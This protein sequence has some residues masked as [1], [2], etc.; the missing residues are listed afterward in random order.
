MSEMVFIS[1]S[2]GSKVVVVVCP[3]CGRISRQIL[4]DVYS[5]QPV[6][7]L[8]AEHKCP[9][10]GA[11]YSSCNAARSNSWANAYNRYSRD[12]QGY[13][14]SIKENY[15]RSL[16][17]QH[18]PAVAAQAPAQ[19]AATAP[20]Q[21]RQQTAFVQMAPVPAPAPSTPQAP[22]QVIN[23]GAIRKMS[24]ETLL[25]ALQQAI[26]QMQAEE[27]KAPE[28]APP[29]KIEDAIPLPSFTS[30]PV[31]PPAQFDALD[32]KIEYWKNQLLD[33]GK[34]NKMINYR[35]TKRATLRILE[36][37]FSELF[38][39][40]ALNEEELTFQ[41]PIDKDSDLRTFS[42]LSLL[43]TLSYPLPVH[44]GDIKTEGTILERQKTL[45]N[46]RTKS[47]LARDEQGTNILYLSFGFIEWKEN[48]VASSPWLKSP[49]L[50][51]PVSLKIESIQAPY[52][53]SRYDDE[54]EVNPTLDYLFNQEYGIDL[55]TFELKDASSIDQYMEVIEDIVDKRGWKL[56]REVSMGLLSFL[57]I[58]MYHDLN[59]NRER[60][61]NNPV[62]RAIT[63]DTSV[64]NV[65]PKEYLNFSF[66]RVAPYDWYQVV[67]SDSS[68]QEAILLSKIGV[69]FV[70]QGPPG[71][72][73]SQ[74]ITNIIAEAL[75][76]GKKVLFVS[77]K[78]AALQV[79]YKRLSEVHLDDFCLALH[80]HKANKKEILD[81]IGDNLKLPHN[82]VKDSVMAELNELFHDREYLN[83]YA[84]EL[85]EE[86]APLGESL[87]VVF[88]KLSKL[89]TAT[90]IPFVIDNPTAV[91]AD[92]FNTM[93]YCVR[94]YAKALA[95]MGGKLTDN[96]WYGSVVT[97]IS[98]EFKSQLLAETQ[99][100]DQQL[101]SLYEALSNYQNKYGFGGEA[102]WNDVQRIIS[103]LSEIEKTP[104]FPF[105]WCSSERRAQLLS[106][107]NKAK[108]LKLKYLSVLTEVQSHFADT[109]FDVDLNAWTES[110][111]ANIAAIQQI[112][113]YSTLLAGDI[114]TRVENVNVYAKA[115]VTQIT[116]IIAKYHEA[117]DILHIDITDT[118]ENMSKIGQIAEALITMTAARREWF[119]TFIYNQAVHQIDIAKS[120]TASVQAKSQALLEH[121][122]PEVF[123]INADSMLERFMTKYNSSFKDSVIAY[124]QDV[125]TI[126]GMS[127]SVIQKTSDDVIVSLLQN[128]KA[129]NTEK[130]RMAENETLICSHF[131]SNY[132]GLDTDWNN[133][134]AVYS[135]VGRQIEM[136]KSN[137][138]SIHIWMQ[139]LLEQWEPEVFEIDTEAML[140][141][142]KTE[143]TGIFRRLKSAYR[144]D[145]KAI[146]CVSKSVGGKINDDVIVSLL[147][148]IKAINTEKQ[149]M[150]EN[151][152]LIRSHFGNYYFGL[153]T[154][155]NSLRAIYSRVGRQIEM[156]KSNFDN[157]QAQMKALLE[158]W[159]PGI[160]S[161]DA[162][163]MLVRFT[164]E[165]SRVFT[166]LMFEYQKDVEFICGMSKSIRKE[167]GDEEII[168]LL[169]KLKD[170]NSE[171]QWF[172]DNEQV[173]RSCFGDYYLG[174]STDWQSLSTGLSFVASLC[175]IFPH[176]IVSSKIID[177]ICDKA[178]HSAEYSKLTGIAHTLSQENIS[179]AQIKSGNATTHIADSAGLSVEKDILPCLS[180]L[181][182]ASAK[183]IECINTVQRH[184]KD[185]IPLADM[186]MHISKAVEVKAAKADL[187][188]NGA[189]NKELFGD[190]YQEIETEWDAIIDDLDKVG[191]LFACKDFEFTTE[192][193]IE[194]LCDDRE[195]RLDLSK[196][197]DDLQNRYTSAQQPV[198]SFV[199]L[200]REDADLFNSS[201][202]DLAMRFRRCIDNYSMLDKWLD[203]TE[204]KAECDKVGLSDFTT[205]IDAQDN[206][207]PGV[208]DAFS[209]GFYRQ[210]SVAVI[211]S[212]ASVQQFRR[213]VH[214]ER[215]N[216]FVVLD[217]KQLAIAQ[218]RIRDKIISTF[219]DTNRVMTANDEMSIL[220]HELGKKRRIMPLRKLFRSIPNLLL[221]LKPCLMMSPLSV[222][223]F[224][225]AE[226]YQFDMVIFDE[227]SQIFPQDAIG[228]IFRGAQVI[229]A[230]D[231]KQLPPTNFFAASTNNSENDYDNEDDKEYEDAIYDSI[232]EETTNVLPNRTLLW[233][234]RSKHEHLIAFSNQEIYKNELVTF[235]SSIEKEEDTGVEFV[236]VEHGAYESGGKNCNVQEAKRCVELVKDHIKKH[237]TRSLG[238]IAFSEK[239]QQAIS[240][241]IQRFREQNPEFEEFFAEDKED[242]FFVKNLENVQGDERD[243][244]IFS[245]GYAKTKDQRANNRPMSMRFG[246]LGHQGGERRLN[247]A[248]TRAKR[249]VKLVSSILPSDI[250]LSRTESEGVRMLRS[251]IEFAMNGSAS[252]RSGRSD[253]G[254]NDD[255]VDTISDYIER[256]GYRIRK[257]VG[258][259]GYRIDIAVEHPEKDGRFIAGIECDGFSYIAV[260]TA[261][262]RDH[263]RKSVLKAMGWSIYRVWSTEW[264]KNPE[265]EGEKLI[266]F[267]KETVDNYH[268]DITPVITEQSV[269]AVPDTYEIVEE[270]KETP[271]TATK[272]GTPDNPYGFDYYTEA[273]WSETPNILQYQ[274]TN[275][276]IEEIKYIVGIEQ[277][278]SKDLLYQRM[279][280]AFGRQK[281]TAPVRNTINQ[282]LRATKAKEILTNS[283][284]FVI[285]AGFSNLRVRIPKQGDTPRPINYISPSEIGLA[286]LT[287]ASHTFG[288]SSE[289]LID[290]TARVLG[291]AR[292]GERIMTC[293]KEALSRLISSGQVK[294]IDGKVNIVEEV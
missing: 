5:R 86:V 235:P 213:R 188:A 285:L 294:L 241:E 40:L 267:I 8:S 199:K 12:A 185:E 46:L 137:S 98:Q 221:T 173:L 94:N 229:I 61:L 146:R 216:R 28:A 175:K 227:A 169:Q 15:Q 82:R 58:S 22:A 17:A 9:V 208:S 106:A 171:K 76:D 228:A 62:I 165:Y 289:G 190:R 209:R 202:I 182:A 222:A 127:K 142:F 138:D 59:N 84:H 277:P 260:K 239:Q 270:I 266:S 178:S 186:T 212:K 16:S 10:C 156:V 276:I 184:A 246:P 148:D 115:L 233:H 236:Y 70:M 187:L 102:T 232:L 136:V 89:D 24:Q 37:E 271:S 130:Q 245:I 253:A 80:S 256:N 79:V 281:A 53:I 135:R 255:F 218:M 41:R 103:M 50:M 4:R 2:T 268:E 112:G 19:F 32:R 65:I 264:I 200:F 248:I 163:A 250:D 67:N 21:Q 279:A 26:T 34:R 243:T 27:S 176:G 118:F 155:W 7:A 119:D 192:E 282:A 244:I 237:P 45:K 230:G 157:I 145:V 259:S 49:I 141:R 69:S 211:D 90:A 234:Y 52:T 113:N 36:P 172:A 20:V 6:C 129:I 1:S 193:F 68:Q 99:G 287:I 143:Y 133:L 214:D 13:N 194:L 91:S 3:K 128:I 95:N 131:G 278:I 39:R 247:V 14:N 60:M 196:A 125:E 72:G 290:E 93:I 158:Q 126:Y 66:D 272:N 203:Y 105:D 81:S 252:L 263:L 152:T 100:L 134:H 238:I 56:V 265:I 225:E 274:G 73:K 63:G 47:K 159:E 174:M 170:I 57:K 109:I 207:I 123:T 97:S 262:D 160:L 38:N 77:E 44:I 107:A 168:I 139:A 195:V 35:E 181:R 217:D 164:T 224:L 231:S 124:R 153:D 251:Y 114:F 121:W 258:C 85:H 275:R 201:L 42:M 55:P 210:W 257:H 261:R 198:R 140:G 293:V 220:L 78:A 74:T 167:I 104:L 150:A 191:D 286:M 288:L 177:I 189:P 71:T 120:H 11:I 215:I 64:A 284:G 206:S 223:Y 101:S 197:K 30:A 144:R 219:P 273:V 29:P 249:N 43:E 161:I 149:R 205:K 87:Y 75:A 291:Y 18:E 162:E 180:A 108:K 51:M 111:N 48:N 88:G 116:E 204:T 92:Q 54:I 269:S 25:G 226:S 33:F 292:K 183:I 96:P 122:E 147:Q 31:Q 154:D 117:I 283:D 23:E 83:Q 151:E 254:S 240:Y 280:G 132:F 110:M 179:D 166:D 242:E